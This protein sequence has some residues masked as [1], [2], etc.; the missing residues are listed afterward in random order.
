MKKLLVWGLLMFGLTA[1]SGKGVYLYDN[2][3][4]PY[5]GPDRPW[6]IIGAKGA[7]SKELERKLCTEGELRIMLREAR[8]P[9]KESE[10]LFSAA[11][12]KEA[13]AEKFLEIYYQL[14]ND[15]RER[16]KKAFERHGY[17][18]NDYGC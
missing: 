2:K 4:C 16:L 9:A 10:G 13:S 6:L 15:S 14:S 18:L 17:S 12:G 5:G 3:D 7:G 1:C 11:C 8:L